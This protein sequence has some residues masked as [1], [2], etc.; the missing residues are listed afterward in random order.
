[1]TSQRFREHLID[2]AVSFDWGLIALADTFPHIWLIYSIKVWV[3][4]IVI[5]Y[6]FPNLIK[7]VVGDCSAVVPLLRKYW[8]NQVAWYITEILQQG[9]MLFN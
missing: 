1:V 6:R 4:E 3:E 2:Y 7:T 9:Y 5:S 8:R